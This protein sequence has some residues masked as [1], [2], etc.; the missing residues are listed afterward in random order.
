M[1]TL[2]EAFVSRYPGYGKVIDD[3]T[4]ACGLDHPAD[5]ADITK[6]NLSTF[7]D[8]EE[9]NMA[10]SSA[11]QYAAKLKSV[12]NTYSDEVSLPKDFN[13]IL[14]LKNDVSQST[15]LTEDEIKL[16]IQYE[17]Q[18]ELEHIVRNEFVVECMTAA[19]NSDVRKFT[20]ANIV[21]GNIVYV[22]Q[23]THIKAT[24]PLS[25]VVEKYIIEKES[26][27]QREMKIKV[28]N[29]NIR[30]ICRR[31]G[32]NQRIKLY[33]R[34]CDMEGEKWQF[35]S[36]HTAR[37]SAATNLYLH[38]MDLLSISK[39]CGHSSV[40]MTCGYIVCPPRIDDNVL[41]Y[42]RSCGDVIA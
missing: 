22:S 32:I 24:I 26:L 21:D 5:W 23:K 40:D 7:V 25:P 9:E 27:P 15:W 31:C 37:R 12:L 4:E 16:L 6:L 42:F 28:F 20:R 41:A 19:R 29:N 8:Y 35:I 30:R 34:G 39:I 11:R 33:R 1:E 13:K 17:P 38:G 36:S 18:T 3:I 14:S 2:R 10:Q